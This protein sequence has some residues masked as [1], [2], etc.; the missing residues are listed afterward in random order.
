MGDRGR[1]GGRSILCLRGRY[2]RE[3]LWWSVGLIENIVLGGDKHGLCWLVKGDGDLRLVI[4]NVWYGV[5]TEVRSWG[6]RVVSICGLSS[7]GGI[8]CWVVRILLTCV[9]SAVCL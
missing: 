4:R 9:R 6:E 2:S 3:D 1:W 5:L 8:I 7:D